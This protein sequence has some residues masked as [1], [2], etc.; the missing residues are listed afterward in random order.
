M[1]NITKMKNLLTL[2]IVFISFNTLKASTVVAVTD[3]SWNQNSTWFPAVHPGCYDTIIIPYGVTVTITAT[4]DL[5]SDCPDSIQVDV[6]GTL[7]FQTGK[8]LKLPCFSKIY[9]HAGGSMGVGGGGGSSTFVEICEDEYWNASMGD[10]TG[11]TVLCGGTCDGFLLP[12]EL[13]TFSGEMDGASRH[14]NLYWTTKSETDND[15]FT[16]ERSIDGT[17]WEELIQIPGAGNSSITLDYTALDQNPYLGYNYYR[18]KQTDYN[19]VYTYSDPILILNNNLEF[20]SEI[21]IFNSAFNSGIINIFLA[22]FDKENVDVAIFDAMGRIVIKNNVTV[23]EGGIAVVQLPYGLA[24]G[25]Y[26]VQVAGRIEKIIL[27]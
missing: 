1:R 20:D 22:D 12:I 19:G 25:S 4:E 9:V 18:L 16:I 2:F 3:G 26:Y 6:Y 27:Q 17:T 13:L 7:E 8:K 24:T 15:Y 11:P 21:L 5:F 14:V 23:T 10:L